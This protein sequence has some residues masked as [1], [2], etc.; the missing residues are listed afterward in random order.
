MMSEE[1]ED[2]MMSEEGEMDYDDEHGSIQ[3]DKSSEEEKPPKKKSGKEKDGKSKDKSVKKL[4]N[5]YG[6]EDGYGDED[7]GPDDY[8]SEDLE[9]IVLANQKKLKKQPEKLLT[10]S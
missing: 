5:D 6:D 1:G 7:L 4:L 2:Q 9:R 3:D 8:D 10:K